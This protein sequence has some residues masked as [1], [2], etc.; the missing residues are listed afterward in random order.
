MLGG[1]RAVAD[2]EA[3]RQRQYE[4]FADT[5]ADR[6]RGRQVI[7]PS[8]AQD[9]AFL[10]ARTAAA[11]GAPIAQQGA[12]AQRFIDASQRPEG[13]SVADAQF[14]AASD[15]N[16]RQTAAGVTDGASLRSAIGAGQGA[17]RGIVGNAGQA[18]AA[19][20]DAHLNR[21]LTALGGAT[22]AYGAQGGAYGTQ[23]GLYG[24][25]R[26]QDVEQQRKFIEQARVN[27]L[28]AL[29]YEDLSQDRA[30]LA[31]EVEQAHRARE[32]SRY[33]VLKDL[34]RNRSLALSE[35]RNKKLAE[36]AARNAAAQKFTTT[37]GAAALAISDRNL[38]TAIRPTSAVQTLV[39]ALR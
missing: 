37:L 24:A 1:D 18:R 13:P 4:L 34:E 22:D 3:H 33:A 38:K 28:A 19:E 25:A 15:L 16:A 6:S 12:I 27:D 17:M 32:D 23:A 8:Q 10:Q 7:D 26:G 21:G 5:Y 29:G 14:N 36:Q 31:Y 11:L 35:E 30:G 9:S 20:Y 39:E 2:N